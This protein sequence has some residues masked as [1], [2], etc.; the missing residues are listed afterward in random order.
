LRSRRLSTRQSVEEIDGLSAETSVTE[1]EKISERMNC[2]E[3]ERLI[4]SCGG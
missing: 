2:A 1:F 4:G 3:A